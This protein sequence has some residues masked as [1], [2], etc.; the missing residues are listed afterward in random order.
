M[1][2]NVGNAMMSHK[3]E[4]KTK[5]EGSI[6][7]NLHPSIKLAILLAQWKHEGF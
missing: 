7:S 4:I 2:E 3:M 6:N 1:Y 5:E